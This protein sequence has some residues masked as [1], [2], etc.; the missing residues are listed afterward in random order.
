M[1]ILFH[2]KYLKT[3]T[4]GYIFI[5]RI[6]FFDPKYIPLETKIIDLAFLEPGI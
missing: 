4:H 6:G 3:E 1:A 2:R 5:V